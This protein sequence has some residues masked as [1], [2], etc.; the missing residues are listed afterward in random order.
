MK[1]NIIAIVA[2]SVLLFLFCVAPGLVLSFSLTDGANAYSAVVE[3]HHRLN[4]MYFYAAI[5]LLVVTIP[6]LGKIR[7]G[8]QMRPAL[9]KSLAYF[10]RT[11]NFITI[12]FLVIHFMPETESIFDWILNVLGRIWD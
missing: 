3:T 2:L 1:R 12:L 6:V 11:V 4:N 5:T 9:S 8:E 10:I 7:Q